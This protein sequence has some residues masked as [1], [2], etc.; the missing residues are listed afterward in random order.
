M[1][2]LFVLLLLPSLLG[3]PAARGEIIERII[4]KVNGEIITLTQFQERQLSAAQAARIDPSQIGPFLR[5]QNARIL[6]DAIDEILILQR[7]QDEGLGL[8]PEFIDEVIESIKKENKITSEEQF[9]EALAQEGLTLDKLRESIEKSWTRRMLLQ[10]DIEPK[11]TVSEDEL[12]ADYETRK[13]TEFTKPATVTLEEI[14]VSDD[15]GGATLAGQIVMRARGGEDFAG[16]AR[17]YSASPSAPK[18]GELGEISQGDMNAALEEVAFGLPV[19]SI[20]DPIPVDGGFR[21][22]RL[23]AKTSG[24]VLAYEQA[25]GR[26]KDRLMMAQFEKEYEKYMADIRDKAVVDLRVREVPL[27]LTGPVPPDTL[28]EGLDPFTLSPTAGMP[29]GALSPGSTPP[30]S[31]DE[32]ISTT[33]Q[34]R[35][36]RVAPPSSPGLSDDEIS[37]TPQTRPE[38]VA[39]PAA[40]EPSEKTTPPSP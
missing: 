32:E 7:A 4:A 24:S 28:L 8:R 39:P 40:P 11:I 3:A 5:Q 34:A 22:L 38:R 27:Q 33:P 10:R 17:Q 29:G 23:V 37:T 12:R 20:S 16:L 9:Q 13:E 2:R 14:F 31:G 35:P 19:G 6:Q 15:S 36:E 25:K 21:I 1:R 26:I 30:P 18:G